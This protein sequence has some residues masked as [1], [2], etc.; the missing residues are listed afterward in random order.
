MYLWFRGCFSGCALSATH[1][2]P[3]LEL[4]QHHCFLCNKSVSEF[5]VRRGIPFDTSLLHE[6]Y[7]A[8]IVH[9]LHL[10]FRRCV[11]ARWM[12][13]FA[14]HAIVDEIL[15]VCTRFQVEEADVRFNA[16]WLCLQYLEVQRS[17]C[18]R[19]KSNTPIVYLCVAISVKFYM[20]TII[21][22][23]DI[24]QCIHGCGIIGWT[25]RTLLMLEMHILHAVGFSVR[26]P[27]LWSFTYAVLCSFMKP[28]SHKLST[29]KAFVSCCQDAAEMLLLKSHA[30]LSLDLNTAVATV[31][32]C[33]NFLYH[34]RLVTH[35][36]PHRARSIEQRSLIATWVSQ[37]TAIPLKEVVT[38]ATCLHK[39]FHPDSLD[40]TPTS[41][42]KQPKYCEH[43]S[44]CAEYPQPSKHGSVEVSP[45]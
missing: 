38:R 20:S 34:E 28:I 39:H 5:M 35:S 18:R 37:V 17:K 36:N 15:T 45:K 10:S 33:G 27:H 31:V 11:P 26:T 24:L 44:V 1:L 23:G 12:Q 30:F 8:D 9:R 43:N 2:H 32:C 3:I 4:D 22:F 16:L 19:P 7:H 41:E 14:Y 40:T 42:Q 6:H 29:T 25:K 21:S 13:A